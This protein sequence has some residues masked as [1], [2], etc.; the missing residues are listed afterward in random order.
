MA[1]DYTFP[2]TPGPGPAGSNAAYFDEAFFLS[3]LDRRFPY[4][5]MQP[6]KVGLN[7]GYELFRAIASV[8]ARASRAIERLET[9]CIIMFSSGG[10]RAEVEVQFS[11]PSATAGAVRLLAGT[12]VAASVTGRKFVTLADVEFGALELG[13]KTVTVR[14]LSNSWQY[15]VAGQSITPVSNITLE[16]EI[17]Q[18]V[19]M[20]QVNPATGLRDFIDKTI[21]VKNIAEATGGKAAMLDGLGLD[22]GVVRGST[23]EDETFRYRVRALPDTVS[24]AAIRRALNDLRDA[25]GVDYQF[26]ETFE[27]TYQTSFDYPSSNSGVPTSLSPYPA[28]LTPYENVFVFDDPRPAYP[29]FANRWLDS[30]EDRAA[31]IV[32]VKAPACIAE[33]GMHFD[34]VDGLPSTRVT[35]NGPTAGFFAISA[36]DL[37]ADLNSDAGAAGCFDGND[38]GLSDFWG[39]WW[40]TMQLLKAAGVSAILELQGE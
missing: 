9:G 20:I 25:W 11:R 32:V 5:Y 36:F 29:P 26:V 3:L 10:A 30:V 33:Y 15:N 22:R 14:A 16:G 1:D 31:F 35:T 27:R 17:D 39:A 18:I 28:Q 8:S 6:L 4:E 38:V 40:E 2:M 12:V 21:V 7:S 34:S 19:R 37:P 23:E 24:P 13:P